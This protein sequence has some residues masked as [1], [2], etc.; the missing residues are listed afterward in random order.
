MKPV[1]RRIVDLPVAAA[2]AAAGAGAVVA[3]G[4]GGGGRGRGR[5][6]GGRWRRPLLARSRQAEGLPHQIRLRGAAPGRR[7]AP[8]SLAPGN[9]SLSRPAVPTR[10]RVTA[11]GDD[12]IIIPATLLLEVRYACM[13]ACRPQLDKQKQFNVQWWR[14]ER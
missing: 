9:D 14:S 2:G 4:G 11:A 12:R 1:R 13:V 7:I 3:A 6:G 10:C 5:W 8:L